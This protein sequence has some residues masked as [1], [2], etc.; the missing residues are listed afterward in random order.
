MPLNS[1][2]A[3]APEGRTTESSSPQQDAGQRRRGRNSRSRKSG[4]RE[5]KF[6]GACDAIKNSVYDVISGRDTFVRTT[7]EIDEYIGWEY[8]EAREF[9]TGMV[10]MR[11]PEL[12]EPALPGENVTAVQVEL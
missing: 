5:T 3:N 12:V 1:D 8:E 7:R 2:G 10:E 4:E 6:Q 11:L 9:R